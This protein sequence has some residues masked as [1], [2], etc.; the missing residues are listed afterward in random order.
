MKRRPG[1][2]VGTIN[3]CII[4]RNEHVNEICMAGGGSP[5][6]YSLSAVVIAN[7]KIED[8]RKDVAEALAHA[9]SDG[10]FGIG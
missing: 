6:K 2:F 10:K 9:Q 8:R 7:A 1:E 5:M 4:F 3:V